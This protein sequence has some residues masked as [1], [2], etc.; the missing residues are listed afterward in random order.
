[1][2]EQLDL[3]DI[4]PRLTVGILTLN[5][6]KRIASCINSA[7]FA[8]Q[9]LVIDSGSKDKTRDIA[10]A[11]GAE[12]HDYPDWQ[13]FAVQRNRVLQHAKGEYIFFLDADEEMPPEMQA[14]IEAVIASGKDEIWKIQWNEV[15]FGKSLTL[16]RSASGIPRMFKTRSI[17]EFS[18]FVHEKPEMNGGQ[19]TVKRFKARLL[20]Y[21]RESVYGCIKKMAQYVQ[22]GA[23]KRAQAG[24]TG[25]VLRGLASGLA[26]FLRLY[27]F[28]R[29]F[30]CGAE[31]FL[32]CFFIA[33]ECFFRYAA[34]KYDLND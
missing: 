30:L 31:G 27:V 7:K 1:M 5:E 10:A 32:F 28:R 13:G 14:E 22:L 11:L 2:T 19:Q 6:E 26:I 34:L 8:D 20:H 16:M 17:R 23:A 33:M 15:A 3:A 29:G 4:R 25:G 21:S 9:I 12:V 24:K 18:G